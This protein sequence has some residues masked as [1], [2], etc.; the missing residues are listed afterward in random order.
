MIKRKW[1]SRYRDLPLPQDQ[2]YKIQS[3]DTASKGGP[4]NDFSVCTTWIATRDMKWHLIDAFRMR[5][6]YPDLKAAARRLAAALSSCRVANVMVFG[7]SVCQAAAT[8]VRHL[9]SASSRSTR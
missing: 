4:E 3:W 6:D 5:L 7:L 8:A 2:L 1:I 9:A